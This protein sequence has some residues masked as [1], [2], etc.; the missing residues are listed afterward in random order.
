MVS[1]AEPR[2]TGKDRLK[3]EVQTKSRRLKLTNDVE[4]ALR[5]HIEVRR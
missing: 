1:E 4:A 3:S 2:T 5:L